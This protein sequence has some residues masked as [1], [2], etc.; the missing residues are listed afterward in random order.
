MN[1]FSD[2]NSDS[3]NGHRGADPL[4]TLNNHH[5]NS[6]SI[7]D[8]EVREPHPETIKVLRRSFIFLVVIGLVLGALVATGI[9]YI[10]NRFDVTGQPPEPPIEQVQ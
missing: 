8:V 2:Q 4:N 1:L 10:L 7:D 3:D 9:I 5:P 6:D